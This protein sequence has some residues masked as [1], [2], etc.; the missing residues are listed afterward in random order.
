MQP[1]KAVG[2]EVISDTVAPPALATSWV[3]A[4]AFRHSPAHT[5]MGSLCC[6]EG[7]H[8][9]HHHFVV[10]LLILRGPLTCPQEDV[11]SDAALR[12][13]RRNECV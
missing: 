8:V 10:P 13:D 9:V 11:G 6:Y 12:P 2:V 3:G 4:E 1:V 5:Q 7:L